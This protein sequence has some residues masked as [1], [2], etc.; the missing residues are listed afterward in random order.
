MF[1]FPR[2]I[3]YTTQRKY[4]ETVSHLLSRLRRI[5]PLIMLLLALCAVT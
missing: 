1:F 4:Y 2:F 3:I 5:M